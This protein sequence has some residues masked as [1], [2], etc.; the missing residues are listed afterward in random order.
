MEHPISAT[1]HIVPEVAQ[2]YRALYTIVY[3]GAAAT[4][5]KIHGAETLKAF[6]TQCQIPPRDIEQS[7]SRLQ[8]GMSEVL[9]L[10]HLDRAQV[11]D[12]LLAYAG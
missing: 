3:D 5:L 8:A 6:L 4:P 9:D 11:T 10:R 12:I 7:M 2:A 1:R